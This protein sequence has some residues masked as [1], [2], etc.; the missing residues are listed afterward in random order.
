MS[1]IPVQ[2]IKEWEWF[3]PGF[4]LLVFAVL[5]LFDFFLVSRNAF[6]NFHFRLDFSSKNVSVGNTFTLAVYPV[7]KYASDLSAAQVSLSYDQ[8]KLLLTDVKAGGFFKN[9]L[10]VGLDTA[11]SSFSLLG[12]PSQVK[13]G[14]WVDMGKPLIVLTFKVLKPTFLTKVYT[15]KFSL[16]YFYKRGGYYPQTVGSYVKL[17]K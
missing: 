8:D 10:V 3:K 7:G 13:S 6:N 9:G 15:N 17:G 1:I 16:V 4:L 12:N 14:N 5:A 11:K 2:K